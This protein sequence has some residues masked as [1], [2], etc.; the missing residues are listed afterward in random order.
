MAGLSYKGYPERYIHLEVH[1]STMFGIASSTIP[2]INHKYGARSIFALSMVK[3]AMQSP[4]V[5]NVD[6]KFLVYAQKSIMYTCT[7]IN[8][9]RNSRN[10]AKKNTIRN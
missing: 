10:E 7:S 4:P 6:A 8:C 1:P 5:N 2:Q 9:Y 3:Q